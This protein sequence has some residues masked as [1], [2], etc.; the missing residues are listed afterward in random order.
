MHADDPRA[1]TYVRRYV[2]MQ[3]TTLCQCTYVL[4]CTLRVAAA[5]GEYSCGPADGSGGRA[6]AGAGA[7]GNPTRASNRILGE[8]QRTIPA[9]PENVLALGMYYGL[10]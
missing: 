3:Y 4:H 5:A 6:E 2:R 9:G 10:V 7:G 8:V 1:C